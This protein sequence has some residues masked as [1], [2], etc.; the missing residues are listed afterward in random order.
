MRGMEWHSEGVILAMRRHGE[1]DAIV[2]VFT[3]DHGRCHGVLRG[4]GASRRMGPVLQL[5]NQVQVTWRARL[6]DHLGTWR[7]EP[8]QSR[9][10]LVMD[11]P[12]QLA[13]LSAVCALLA[14][15]LPE[16][17]AHAGLYAHSLALLDALGASHW[18]ESYLS[19]ELA[20]LAETGFGLDLS[21]CAIT[22][23][24]QDLAFVSPRTGRAVARGAA[25]EWEDRLLPL[26][27]FLCGTGPASAQD[28]AQGFR[29]TAHFLA[30]HL[31]PSLGAKPIPAARQRF[32]DIVLRGEGGA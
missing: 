17:Q 26:P 7:L 9:A 16:R 30:Q 6:S 13:G 20:L 2:D 18:V 5:G 31:A 24:T 21:A 8:M 10:G 19:W 25:P 14:F 4:G 3:P 15:A 29:L 1:A 22:G 12:A 28:L 27:R 32:V 11:D 23:Q